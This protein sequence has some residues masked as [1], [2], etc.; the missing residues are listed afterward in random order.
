MSRI[1]LYLISIFA[2]VGLYVMNTYNYLLFHA[3]AEVFSIVVACGIFMVAYN[4]RTLV[5]RS[6]VLFMGI[7]FLFVAAVDLLHLLAFDGMGVFVTNGANLATQLWLGARYIQ[8]IALF[9]TP[10]LIR[11]TIEQRW[12][13]FI[14]GT[15]TGLFLASVGLGLF[16][17]AFVPGE[18]LTLFKIGSEF[19]ISAILLCAA[20]LF[21]RFKRHL[22]RKVYLVLIGAI[23][24]T[25][26]SEMSFTLYTDPY[27][28]ANFI[29]HLL[30]IVAFCL[31]YQAVIATALSR[32]F[33]I[34]FRDLRQKEKALEKA[35]KRLKRQDRMKNEFMS[36][37]AHELKSPL[38]PIV[39]YSKLLSRSKGLDKQEKEQLRIIEENAWREKRLVDDVLD[40]VK[41]EGRM[42]NFSMDQVD[43]N[44][45]LRQVVE[46]EKEMTKKTGI[47]LKTD[48]KRMPK[49]TGDYDRILQVVRNLLSN[50]FKFTEKGTVEISAKHERGKVV[51]SVKDEGI[52]IEP[53]IIPKL[54]KKFQQADSRYKTLGTGLGLA[55]SK[56]IIQ[57]HGG[58]I[59][60]ESE[61]K[62]K[63]ARFSFYIP[64][65]GA[66][67]SKNS[68]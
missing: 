33:S 41:L 34:L 38:T 21:Y 1:H 57:V 60:A 49:V 42:M 56:E 24:A 29:G 55:I 28:I 66:S 62:G 40:I 53:E 31:I 27:G 6:Y 19:I 26:A 47:R 15:A 14:W 46:E 59:W 68:S 39:G 13:W 61:G 11:R 10:L 12:I 9:I 44:K 3:I 17:V 50:A 25:I 45:L 63:G 32:P 23:F 52:G 37:A 54:F 64:V 7:S 4:Y 22:D 20:Y 2:A 65:T 36:I 48:I 67:S 51:V 18:G 5:K 58:K 43:M 30:K 8:A 16:P 35:N